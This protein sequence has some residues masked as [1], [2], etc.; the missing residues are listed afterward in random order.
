MHNVISENS[1]NNINALS[2]YKNILHYYLYTFPFIYKFICM[3]IELNVKL[4]KMYYKS[5]TYS[6]KTA[7]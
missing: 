5:I 3:K 2:N 1:F 7:T 6:K 4:K